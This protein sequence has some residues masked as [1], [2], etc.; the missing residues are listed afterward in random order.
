MLLHVSLIV[1]NASQNPLTRPARTSDGRDVILR[2]MAIGSE[3]REH[4]DLLKIIAQDSLSFLSMNHTLPLLGLIELEDI[5]FGVFPKAAFPVSLCYNF[6][7]KASV[8]DVLD[9]IVQCL[10]V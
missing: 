8:G 6:W 7:A 2:V 1:D 5:T 3:G 9:I 4:I 10:E